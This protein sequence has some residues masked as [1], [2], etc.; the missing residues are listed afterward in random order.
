MKIKFPLH[1]DSEG[2]YIFDADGQVFA[3]VRGWGH[4]R[5][6]GEAEAIREQ[7]ER[8]Q[9][10]AAACNAHEAKPERQCKWTGPDESDCSYDTE[11]G[12]S[13]ILNHG[14]PEENNMRFCPYCG[15]KLAAESEAE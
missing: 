11:C 8:C 7:R 14:T 9:F 15:G 5:H 13:A 12:E 1:A 6:Q 4:L 3:E 2:M 10:V